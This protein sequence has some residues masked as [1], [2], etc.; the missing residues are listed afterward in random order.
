MKRHYIFR[1]IALI[2]ISLTGY[3]KEQKIEEPAAVEESQTIETTIEVETK[4]TKETQA[5]TFIFANYN[6]LDSVFTKDCSFTEEEIMVSDYIEEEI[7]DENGYRPAFSISRINVVD[8]EDLN[9]IPKEI[10]VIDVNSYYDVYI[11][12]DGQYFY[13]VDRNGNILRTQ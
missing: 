6:I 4:D 11:L 7:T 2:I 10:I 1:L 12:D 8:V 9:T 13:Y 3:Q 5:D